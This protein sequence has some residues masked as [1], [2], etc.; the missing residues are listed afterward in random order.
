MDKYQNTKTITSVQTTNYPISNIDFPAITVCSNTRVSKSRYNAAMENSKLPWKNLT[1]LHGVGVSQVIA[2]L[3]MFDLYPGLNYSDD[4]LIYKNY[5]EYLTGLMAAVCTNVPKNFYIFS[6]V[7][8]AVRSI[9]NFTLCR[10][11]DVDNIFLL[12]CSGCTFL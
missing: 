7:N 9:R 1:E 3:V 5:S 10:Y 4:S 8:V 6:M 12:L 2:N 11:I